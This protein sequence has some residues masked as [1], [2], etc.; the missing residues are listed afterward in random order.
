V[1]VYAKETLRWIMIGLL[2]CLAG[3]FAH[4][5][6]WHI[7]DTMYLSIFM[8]GIILSAEAVIYLFYRLVEQII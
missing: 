5:G 4:N 6:I 8:T 1:L 3:I 2:F 7:K